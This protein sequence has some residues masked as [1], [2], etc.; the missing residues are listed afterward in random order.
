MTQKIKYDF[1]MGYISTDSRYNWYVATTSFSKK[2][3]KNVEKVLG[4]FSSLES[5]RKGACE[6]FG[7]RAKNHSQLLEACAS[8]NN[9]F[10]VTPPA[11]GES[12]TK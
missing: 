12:E 10:P 6:I 8:I 1:G 4:W 3:N 11:A 9:N 2:L 7:R 5:A